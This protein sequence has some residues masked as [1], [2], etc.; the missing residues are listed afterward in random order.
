MTS[1]ALKLNKQLK[2]KRSAKGKR[3]YPFPLLTALR[4]DEDLNDVVD[5]DEAVLDFDD[6]QLPQGV[7]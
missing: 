1:T 4:E 3:L 6:V 7:T 2:S 5:L